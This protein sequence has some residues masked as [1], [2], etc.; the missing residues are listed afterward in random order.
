[1]QIADKYALPNIP[2]HICDIDMGENQNFQAEIANSVKEWG[3]GGGLQFDTMGY[4]LPQSSFINERRI[5][6]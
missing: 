4:R 3:S 6:E 5:G 2:T 1:M